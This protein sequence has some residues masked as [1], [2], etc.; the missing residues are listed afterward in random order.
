MSLQH[1]RRLA[2][3][4]LLVRKAFENWAVVVLAGALWKYLPLSRRELHV[5]SRGPGRLVVPL[6]RDAGTLY[7]VLEIFA[8]S[9]YESGW[10]LEDTPYVV[11]IGA[12][13]GAF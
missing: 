10:R 11:D 4:A 13:I 2:R 12:N 3:E 8:Y 5:R 1:T 9:V 7:P 6:T